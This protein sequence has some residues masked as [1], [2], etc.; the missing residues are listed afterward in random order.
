NCDVETQFAFEQ[1]GAVAERLHINR[2]RANP[3][4]LTQYQI[5]TISGGFTYGDDVA[6]GKILAVQLQHFLADALRQFR[7]KERLILAIC[8]GF[9]VLLKAGMIMPPDEDGPVATLAHNAGGKFEDRWIHLEAQPGKCPF[10]K[11]YQRLYLPVAHGEG[12]FICRQQ[13]LLK[14]LI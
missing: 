13:W 8:N 4:L 11:G 6:A 14:G 7:D 5:L 12:N 3:K 1:A 10:L 2:L 9:Q